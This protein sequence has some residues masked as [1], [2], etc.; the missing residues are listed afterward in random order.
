[1]QAT[2]NKSK[3]VRR[4]PVALMVACHWREI[5]EDIIASTLHQHGKTTG[6]PKARRKLTMELPTTHVH[7]IL[8]G[9][10]L[11]QAMADSL[12]D[13]LHLHRKHTGLTAKNHH[14]HLATHNLRMAMLHSPS[15]AHLV[16]R[17]PMS[18]IEVTNSTEGVVIHPEVMIH[19]VGAVE[20]R[21]PSHLFVQ[22]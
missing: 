13:L 16:I 18:G 20:L 3:D 9:N 1:M 2:S 17:D 5:A 15:A 19:I 11:P 7:L 4:D 22:L 8:A 12:V 6:I 14:L 10:L 21:I